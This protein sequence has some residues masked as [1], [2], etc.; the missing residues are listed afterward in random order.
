MSAFGNN[1]E[2]AK[3]MNAYFSPV[4]KPLLEVQQLATRYQRGGSG[5]TSAADKQ[6]LWQ[7]L[8]DV[9]P[10]RTSALRF[11][12]MPVLEEVLNTTHSGRKLLSTPQRQPHT[13]SAI[14][15]CLSF[16]K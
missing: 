13:A 11:I 16:S 10:D 4:I 9:L 3:A 2:E 5:K 8:S 12:Y 14:S 7:T 6:R 15:N 1:L